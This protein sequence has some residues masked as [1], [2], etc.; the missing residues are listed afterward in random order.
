MDRL[1]RHFYEFDSFRIDVDER[2]LLKGGKPVAL[3][4]KVFDILLALVENCGRTLSK[5]QLMQTVWPESFVEEGNLNRNVST[6][7]KALGEDSHYPRYIK[8][9]PKQGYRFVGQVREVWDDDESVLVENRS[10]VHLKFS[11]EI[12][13][14]EHERTAVS[15]VALALGIFLV[16]VTVAV[17]VWVSQRSQ[18]TQRQNLS[19]SKESKNSN[20]FE[21]YEKA[22]LLWQ[23]RAGDKL[24]EATVML[25]HAVLADPGFAPAHA[26]LADCYAFDYTNWR[27]AEATAREAIRLDETLGQPY[28]TIGFVRAFWEWR[29]DEAEASFKRAIELSPNYA[30]AHQ[31]YASLL[32]ATARTD[33]AY[34]EMRMALALEPDSTSINVDLC[35]TL[36]FLRRY[37]EAVDQCKR[38]LE[39]DESNFNAHRQLYEIYNTSEMYDEAVREYFILEEIGLTKPTLANKLKE[40]FEKGGIRKFWRTRIKI[41][42]GGNE[43]VYY[44]TAQ[45]YARLGNKVAAIDSL[46]KA[47]EK[48]D[49]DFFFFYS[50][51]A[52]DSIRED[53][54]FQ[55]LIGDFN[56]N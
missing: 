43:P 20:A 16:L 15:R 5:D 25:E 51:P 34:A 7:R 32:S 44:Q 40:G 42:T 11:E 52:F 55:K 54:R 36:Y 24:H 27:K 21:L 48:R 50:D 49:F 17:S 31:W 35:Q 38:A 3:T 4:P 2:Q 6:L 37:D 12:I 45:H 30:T 22:R 8:T 13:R 1:Q 33:A 53:P 18:A 47:F 26:A 9:K 46:Q 41:L 10:R 29:L 28:A 23:T 39:L 19:V 14:N 56:P